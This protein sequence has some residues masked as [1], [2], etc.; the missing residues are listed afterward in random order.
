[1]NNLLLEVRQWVILSPNV[2]DKLEEL[3]LHSY[4]QRNIQF[5][6][7]LFPCWVDEEADGFFVEGPGYTDYWLF[8]AQTCIDWEEGFF[9]LVS[10]I[11]DD[12]QAPWTVLLSSSVDTPNLA[13]L[14]FLLPRGRDLHRRQWDDLR[15]WAVQIK[16]LELL[17][18]CSGGVGG[19]IIGKTDHQLVVCLLQNYTARSDELTMVKWMLDQKFKLYWKRESYRNVPWLGDPY[20]GVLRWWW[21]CRFTHPDSPW[22]KSNEMVRKAKNLNRTLM[23]WSKQHKRIPI[24]IENLIFEYAGIRY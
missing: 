18:F 13:I 11:P 9:Y 23:L 7:K 19:A 8:A 15:L 12:W 4:K 5:L 14:K 10:L 22:K 17:R 6:K 24:E 3:I 1:M 2:E 20:Y 21:V 16:D